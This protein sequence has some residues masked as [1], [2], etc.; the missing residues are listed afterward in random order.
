[1][2][3]T[4]TGQHLLI[5]N[6]LLKNCSNVRMI[7]VP[8]VVGVPGQD[9]A[10]LTGFLHMT[11]RTNISNSLLISPIEFLNF[12]IDTFG[13]PQSIVTSI[14]YKSIIRIFAKASC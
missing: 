1:M 5:L 4:T 6:L 7:K 3:I 2:I 11:A 12:D 8:M 14:L 10:F 13:K 9:P